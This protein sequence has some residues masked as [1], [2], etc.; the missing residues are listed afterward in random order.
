MPLYKASLRM[1][2]DM[3]GQP[4]RKWSNTYFWDA[5][6]AFVAADATRNLWNGFLK[7]VSRERVYCYEVYATDLAEGTTDYVVLPIAPGD[8]RGTL[9]L[10]ASDPY[11]PKVCVAVEL[12]VNGS[13]PSR[14]F[15]R[16]GLT[17]ADIAAGVTLDSTLAAA[18]AD[19]FGDAAEGFSGLRDV[20]N[21]P[22][23][24]VGKVRLTTREFGRESTNLVPTP[25]PLG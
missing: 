21:Q 22:I 13:R 18:I 4:A 3:P 24:G 15:F 7:G 19:A 8:Q 16:P 2:T 12:L 20:D 17:E 5:A 1:A 14:K 23:F 11:M 25:P 10:P 6:S 9:P